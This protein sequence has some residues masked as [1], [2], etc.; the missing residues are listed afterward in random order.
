[1]KRK[2]SYI[3]VVSIFLSAVVT[4]CKKE[5]DEE[6]VMTMTTSVSGDVKILLAG[7]GSVTIDWGDG[8]AKDTKE[9]ANV[10][11]EF[12]H[13]YSVSNTR[14]IRI[15]GDNI[16]GLNC[17]NNQLTSLDVSNNTALKNI[18]CVLN[19]LTSL[20]VS[21][22]IA[23]TE[24]D[25]V[26]NPLTS[27]DVSNNTLLKE[28]YCNNNSFTNLDVSKNTALTDLNCS[29]NQLTNL[30]VSKNIALT[31][32][33]CS[34]NQLAN[35]DVNKNIDLE[36][37]LC[38][39]NIITDLDVSKNTLLKQLECDNNQL[40]NLDMSNNAKLI[41]LNCAFNIISDTKLNILFGTL[42]SSTGVIKTIYIRDNPGTHTCN[43]SIAIEKG[44]VVDV[45]FPY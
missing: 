6:K 28:L 1:M 40:M 27:L 15:Y 36:Y 14:T 34:R 21:K 33:S 17:R 41:R 24:L 19:Q 9:L 4:S 20:D 23:L 12:I 2:T 16:T 5:K 25:C 3:I 29:L 38:S 31:N 42:H 45:Y 7:T 32:L 30:D 35:L 13:N 18:N 37:L 22:N 8:S 39:N 44:W 11:T 26:T 10:N 43:P